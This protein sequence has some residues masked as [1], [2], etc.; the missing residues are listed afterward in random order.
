MNDLGMTPDVFILSCADTP[1][2][3]KFFNS[4]TEEE[5]EYIRTFML[6]YRGYGNY[7]LLNSISEMMNKGSNIDDEL[8]KLMNN[9]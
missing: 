8:N 5:K 6:A 1:E 2:Q 7:M 9:N 3:I 4:L